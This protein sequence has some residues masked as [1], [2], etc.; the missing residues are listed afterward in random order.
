MSQE[1]EGEEEEKGKKTEMAFGSVN[2]AVCGTSQ[3]RSVKDQLTLMTSDCGRG[4]RVTSHCHLDHLEIIQ[5]YKR[6]TNG[7]FPVMLWH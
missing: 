2:C 5:G 7:E 1:E 6:C 3:R 4:L